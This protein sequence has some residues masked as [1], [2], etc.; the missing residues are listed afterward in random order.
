[1]ASIE[2]R[3]RMTGL[4]VLT[5]VH[6][7]TRLK[8]GRGVH[9]KWTAAPQRSRA[10]KLTVIRK[11]GFLDV[12]SHLAGRLAASNSGPPLQPAHENLRRGQAPPGHIS[13]GQRLAARTRSPGATWSS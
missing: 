1:M 10:V 8:R 5:H 9:R 12:R 13:P 7:E 11:R 4:D 6:H 3:L 2:A